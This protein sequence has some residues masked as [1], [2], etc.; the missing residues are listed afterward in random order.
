MFAPDFL[1]RILAR[2]LG[3]ESYN[4]VRV[5]P[6]NCSEPKTLLTGKI[7]R[8][9]YIRTQN[10]CCKTYSHGIQTTIGREKVDFQL[11]QYVVWLGKSVLEWRGRQ[12]KRIGIKVTKLKLAWSASCRLVWRKL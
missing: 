9:I 6:E 2:K 12:L 1:R 3:S 8:G 4:T 11:D 7:Y 10:C 5:H